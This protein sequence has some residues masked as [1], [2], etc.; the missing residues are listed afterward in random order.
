M[1]KS[2]SESKEAERK[3]STCIS[4]A[5]SL[6]TQFIIHGPRILDFDYLISRLSLSFVS[7]PGWS[8]INLKLQIAI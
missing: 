1:D 2:V 5:D 7:S 4:S 8:P 3:A 6:Y